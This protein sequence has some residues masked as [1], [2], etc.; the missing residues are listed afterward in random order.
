[1]LLAPFAERYG[2]MTPRMFVLRVRRAN[3]LSKSQMDGGDAL[4][5]R[6]AVA[7]IEPKM[8][9]PCTY[10]AGGGRGCVTLPYLCWTRSILPQRDVGVPHAVAALTAGESVKAS[11]FRFF[12]LASVPLC[13]R[14][15][16]A[17]WL[18]LLLFPPAVMRRFSWV[19][20][21]DAS[22]DPIR[23]AFAMRVKDGGAKMSPINS[24]DHFFC[25]RSMTKGTSGKSKPRIKTYL[26]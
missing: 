8:D 13:L 23:E 26:D 20:P 10:R 9:G 22:C 21:T 16:L 19:F 15:K 4:P 7:Y 12:G 24:T 6:S 14:G 2:G 1:M 11:I 5:S 3:A 18:F 17:V 25:V